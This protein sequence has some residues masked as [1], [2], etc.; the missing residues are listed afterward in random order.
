MHFIRA[1]PIV[2]ILVLCF[3]VVFAFADSEWYRGSSPVLLGGVPYKIYTSSEV[4]L[5]NSDLVPIYGYVFSES[6]GSSGNRLMLYSFEPTSV[7][8]VNPVTGTSTLIEIN[9]PIVVNGTKYYR[10]Q[11]LNVSLDLINFPIVTGG[12]ALESLNFVINQFGNNGNIFTSISLFVISS[13]SWLTA[14]VRAVIGAP[15]LLFFMLSGFVGIG[16]GFF[17]RFRRYN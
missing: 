17:D 9:S 12:T 4:Y 14:F 15:L 5:L 8:Q 16:I 6:L 3:G 13:V 10:S 1:F 2:L 7:S 11:T